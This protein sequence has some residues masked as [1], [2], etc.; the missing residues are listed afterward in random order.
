MKKK[1]LKRD[2]KE[3]Q[4]R[5]KILEAENSYIENKYKQLYEAVGKMAQALK[6]EHPNEKKHLK[7]M[8]KHR[9]EW[10]EMWDWVNIVAGIH[11]DQSDADDWY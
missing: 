1:N 3:L 6:A 7:M 5:I 8:L 11:E 4:K 9:R 10:P 2:V